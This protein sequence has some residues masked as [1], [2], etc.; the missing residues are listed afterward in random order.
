MKEG[1]N[2]SLLDDVIKKHADDG[3]LLPVLQEAQSI[4]GY[5]PEDVLRYLS[6]RLNVPLSR[7][8]G[9]VTFYSQFYLHPRGRHVIK[10]CQGTACH[11]RGA[12][13]VL[14][15]L[16]RELRVEPGETTEN[17]DFSLETVACVG[18]CFLGPV[19][20]VD[21]DYYGKLTPKGAVDVLK[22]YSTKPEI[23][24]A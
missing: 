19:I 4:Y 1:L 12:K 13:G 16:T 20:M 24:E 10:S 17:L 9:V 22:K 2:L 14:E 7:I 6:R 21:D 3:G 15:S 8:Y 5:L 11:V 18:T 23:K